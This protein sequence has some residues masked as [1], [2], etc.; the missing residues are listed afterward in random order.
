VGCSMEVDTVI[1]NCA[2]VRH[3]GVLRAG[4][5]IDK[6]KIVAI[7]RDTDLPAARTVIDGEG[8]YVIPGLVDAHFHLE[9]PPGVDPEE[10][11]RRETQACA[12]GGCTTIIHLLAPADDI[13]SKA[14]EFVEFYQKHGYVDIALSARIYTK[15]N[16]KQI[17]RL[18]DYGITSV[19]LLLPYKGSEAVWKG[20]VGGIDDGI[21][22][23]TFEEVGRLAKEGRNIF[24]RVHCENVEI[25]MKLKDRF[26]EKGIEPSSWNEVRPRVCE[27]EA[28]RKCLYLASVTE[29]PIYVVHM[30][31]KEGISLV[32]KARSEGMDVTAETCIQ[33]LVGNR[34]NVDRILSKVNPPIREAGDNRQL[35]EA[36]ENGIIDVVATDHAPVPKA[37]KSDLW[38]A[39]VGIAGAETFLP[40][41]LSE[42]VNKGKISLERMVEVCCYNPAKRFGLAP[43]KGV[44]CIGSDADLVLVDLNKKGV[45]PEKPIYSGSDFSV[46]AGREIKGWPKFTMLRGNIVAKDG[47]VT[48]KAGYGRYVT[49]Q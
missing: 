6:G 40:L 28:M 3:E 10:N 13:L 31:I 48:G 47:K 11:I 24:A 36:L 9:Y 26:V 27:E 16:I 33:Y 4:L 43:Q 2:I 42:G 25:F 34:E 7:A 18:Y 17:R 21:V 1:K 38:D 30:T 23:L 44:L 20:R 32:A 39:T 15:E 14:D 41:M 29:C 46:F 19:K 37:L 35:W 49:G 5:A 12:A 22:Y 45:L 8:N